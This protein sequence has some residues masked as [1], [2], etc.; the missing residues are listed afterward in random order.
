M[1]DEMVCTLPGYL[2]LLHQISRKTA[3]L[4]NSGSIT[5]KNLRIE[6]AQ[7]L[8]NTPNDPKYQ[9]IIFSLL[10]RPNEFKFASQVAY[11]GTGG[12]L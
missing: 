9:K 12:S 2:R 5:D 11:G 10:S 6:R 1:C 8:I 3:I 4:N 7:F